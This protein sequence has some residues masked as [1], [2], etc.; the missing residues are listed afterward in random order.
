MAPIDERRL[1]EMI[2]ESQDL[3]VD[4]MRGMSA[5]LP[6][7]EHIAHTPS[8][9]DDGDAV[10]RFVQDRRRVLRNGG[11]GLGAVAAAGL[12]GTSFGTAITTILAGPAAAS[13]NQGGSKEV[14][15]MIFETA[16]SLENLAVAT[17]GAA[18]QLPFFG[19]NAV[20]QKFA[21]TTMQQ[22]ADHSA[23]FQKQ[24]VA[25]G[26]KEQKGVSPKY[27]PVVEQMKPTLTDYAA[28]VKLAATLEE[29]AQDTYIAN[30]S[31]LPADET[32][33]LMASVLAIETQHLAT[34]RA[35]G[36]LLAANAPQ[37][38]AIPTDLA[39]LPAA[40]G[41]VAFP[42]PFEEANLASPPEEGV[43]K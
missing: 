37:F 12:M 5:T 32:R 8:N 7:L 19:D 27:G 39:N 33:Q 30:L 20:V 42:N 13:T 38:I 11:M 4:A 18:L 16:P 26:G 17:Y 9:E 25:L 22:H 24:A 14:S 21:Q 28:V 34:L 29:V 40:A 43:V 31:L 6:Q 2:T 41:S 3:Q 35:V 23:A 15:I 1:D 10:S 36:A